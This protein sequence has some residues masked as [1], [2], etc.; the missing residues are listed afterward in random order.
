MIVLLA[1]GIN[2]LFIEEEKEYKQIAKTIENEI[3]ENEKPKVIIKEK[4]ITKT[5]TKY[6]KK[7]DPKKSEKE[8]INIF[9]NDLPDHDLQIKDKTITLVKRSDETKKYIV[10]IISDKTIISTSSGSAYIILN[11]IINDEGEENKFSISFNENYMNYLDSVYIQVTNTK[12]ETLLRCDGTFLNGVSSDY[13]YELG[14]D[15]SGENLS[16]YITSEKEKPDIGIR[17][18]MNKFK[19]LE[20]IKGLEKIKITNAPPPELN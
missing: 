6:I 14:I 11:G 7:E 9:A 2:S 4:I 17:L 12:S 15:I 19:S 8:S 5:I 16:C 1:M 3:V 20:N 13:N 18:S 10:S